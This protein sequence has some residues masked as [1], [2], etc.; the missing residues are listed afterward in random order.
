MHSVHFE[1]LQERS[2]FFFL[3]FT[4][5]PSSPT[6]GA[7]DNRSCGR[8][9]PTEVVQAAF[10]ARLLFEVILYYTYD[11]QSEKDTPLCLRIANTL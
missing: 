7:Q 5:V 2:R 8:A 11:I 1:F 6:E 10:W 4:F 9:C 3:A